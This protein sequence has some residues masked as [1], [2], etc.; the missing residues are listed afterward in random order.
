MNLNDVVNECSIG[1]PSRVAGLNRQRI[2]S[3][4][5]ASS[6][7]LKP[8]DFSM[9]ILKTFPSTP[10]KIFKTTVP[11]SS[12]VLE[13]RGYSGFLQSIPIGGVLTGSCLMAD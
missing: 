8:E 13:A 5:A 11:S 4:F 1:F 6:K 9:F 7:R 12:S 2:V 3:V 10:I